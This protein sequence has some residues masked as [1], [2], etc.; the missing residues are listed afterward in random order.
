MTSFNINFF[1]S[2]KL[3]Y[4]Y[5]NIVTQQEQKVLYTHTKKKYGLQHN[6][7]YLLPY[8]TSK[9]INNTLLIIYNLYINHNLSYLYNFNQPCVMMKQ[10]FLIICENK[11][12][13]KNQYCLICQC[14]S[15]LKLLLLGFR[16]CPLQQ[17][18][19]YKISK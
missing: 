17:G 18:I 8:Q 15:S 1:L 2:L 10:V 14:N 3:K 12:L 7:H 19:C 13:Q 5:D 6:L 16:Y 4:F 11:C 9:E